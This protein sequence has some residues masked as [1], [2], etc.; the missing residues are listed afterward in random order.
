MTQALSAR[1]LTS[2]RQLAGTASIVF[3]K[4]GHGY[5]QGNG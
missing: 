4:D 2:P 1:D 3:L 5:G